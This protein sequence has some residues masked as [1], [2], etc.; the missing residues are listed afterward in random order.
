[1]LFLSKVLVDYIK[2]F[3]LTR[4]NKI[5]I[6]FYEALRLDMLKR[7]VILRS[8]DQDQE[9]KFKEFQEHKSAELASKNVN[10]SLLKPIVIDCETAIAISRNYLVLPHLC[11]ILRTVTYVCS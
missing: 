2:H 3:F 11:M 4:F 5:N 1:M 10:W 9:L 7:M 6:Y 8:E